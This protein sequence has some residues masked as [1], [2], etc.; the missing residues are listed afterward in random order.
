M[1]HRCQVERDANE[2]MLDDYNN[3]QAPDWYTLED[4]QPCYFFQPRARQTG[5]YRGDD[6]LHTVV[7]STLQMLMPRDADVTPQDRINEIVDRR[8]ETVASGRYNITQVLLRPRHKLVI[9]E[10]VR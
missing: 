7:I 10:S 6:Q 1:T 9:L 5:E 8:G 2:G 3:P 4:E